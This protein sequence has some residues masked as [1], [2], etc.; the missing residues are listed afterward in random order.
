MLLVGDDGVEID[1]GTSFI[2]YSSTNQQKYLLVLLDNANLQGK[3]F[4]WI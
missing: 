3:M 4:P 1:P 2:S